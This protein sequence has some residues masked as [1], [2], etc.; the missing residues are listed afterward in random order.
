MGHDYYYFYFLISIFEWF[1]RIP[2]NI[3]RAF[4]DSLKDTKVKTK[5]IFYDVINTF[6]TLIWHRTTQIERKPDDATKWST[7]FA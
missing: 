1:N 6:F 4:I 7:I 5:L 3:A 2:I